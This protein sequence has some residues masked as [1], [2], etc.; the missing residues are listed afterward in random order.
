[1]NKETEDKC[2]E[3][4]LKFNRYK[5]EHRRIKVR[6]DLY[7]LMMEDML[8]WIRSFVVKWSRFEEQDEMLSLSFDV[9]LFCLENYKEHY[10]VISHF[11]KYSRYYMMNRYAK[12]DKVRIPIDELKEIMSLGVSPIDGTF[13][14][15][16]TLQQFRAVVPETHLMV[17]DD[18]VSSL[19]SAD[20]YRHKSKNVGMSDNAYNKVKAGYIPIIKLILGR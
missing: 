3:L 20:R 18:A 2:Q 13:E 11:Y 10:S 19:S 8:L 4:I 17:W 14:K 15:L 12:K 1:M 7:E 6:N 16:L 5:Q 9:F